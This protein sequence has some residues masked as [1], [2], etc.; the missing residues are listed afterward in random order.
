MRV[1]NKSIPLEREEREGRSAEPYD[2]VHTGAD[3]PVLIL[4]TPP[5]VDT[6]NVVVSSGGRSSTRTP[7]RLKKLQFNWVLDG[8]NKSE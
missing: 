7:P 2:R 4:R 5:R 1:S 6:N 3:T 8:N